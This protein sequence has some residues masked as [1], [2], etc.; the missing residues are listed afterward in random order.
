MEWI[1][2]RYGYCAG[3]AIGDSGVIKR[4]DDSSDSES[5]S[6]WTWTVRIIFAGLPAKSGA[7]YVTL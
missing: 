2:H 4:V 5:Y 1:V 6:S 3:S 7:S